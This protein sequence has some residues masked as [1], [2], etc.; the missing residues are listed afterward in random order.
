MDDLREWMTQ[1]G[2]AKQ[3]WPEA[4][5]VVTALPRTATGKVQKF[6]LRDQAAVHAEA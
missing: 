1:S 5:E 4:L 6:T 3:Y 2:A